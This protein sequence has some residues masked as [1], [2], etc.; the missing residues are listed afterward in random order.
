MTSHS[1]LF[2]INVQFL[3]KWACCE[4]HLNIL[5][6]HELRNLGSVN[7]KVL[8]FPNLLNLFGSFGLAVGSVFELTAPRCVRSGAG[9]TI[10]T[11]GNYNFIRCSRIQSICVYSCNI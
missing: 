5:L 4:S 8:T 3:Q 6:G 1:S 2:Y 11:M 7:K 9:S 10:N